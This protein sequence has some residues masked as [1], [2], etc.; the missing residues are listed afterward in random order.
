MKPDAAFFVTS[1]P[2]RY[3]EDGAGVFLRTFQRY[4]R[5][6]PANGSF[7]VA[8]GNGEQQP[9]G[10]A[11]TL[12]PLMEAEPVKRTLA[13]IPVLDLH[14]ELLRD[15][16]RDRRHRLMRPFGGAL[17]RN[18]DIKERAVMLRQESRGLP[19]GANIGPFEVFRNWR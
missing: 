18:T 8:F 1:G 11:L 6:K 13:A 4:L 14:S 2:G 16:G 5:L 10:R 17:Y 15:R 7:S 12:A 3:L 19:E 9:K